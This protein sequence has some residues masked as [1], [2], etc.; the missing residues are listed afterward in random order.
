M[1]AA[2]TAFLTKK[3]A[4]LLSKLPKSLGFSL[5][6]DFRDNLYNLSSKV[7]PSLVFK[8][9]MVFNLAVGFQDVDIPSSERNQ[10]KGSVK[11]L[12]YSH[13]LCFEKIYV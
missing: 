4:G 6:I 9:G 5:G 13:S 10:A 2:A 7:D 11:V 8:P 3:H 12:I 1:H